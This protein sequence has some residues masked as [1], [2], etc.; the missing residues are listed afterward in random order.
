MKLGF[1]I[2]NDKASYVAK[3]DIICLFSVAKATALN[4]QRIKPFVHLT[5]SMFPFL[6]PMFCTIYSSFIYFIP[7][8][9]I[10]TCSFPKHY[11][12]HSTLLENISI[13]FY[14]KNQDIPDFFK[15]GLSKSLDFVNLYICHRH[16]CTAHTS[17][18]GL[19]NCFELRCM[20]I[21]KNYS[22]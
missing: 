17:Y 16:H 7:M 11:I 14:P 5:I 22:H 1:V 4:K 12:P 19:E 9:S 2:T 6:S 13:F 10:H 8:C 3:G 18:I 21:G 15:W 20:H